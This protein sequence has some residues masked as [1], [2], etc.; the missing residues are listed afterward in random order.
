MRPRIAFRTHYQIDEPAYMEFVVKLC[1]SPVQSAYREVVAHK[2]SQE[3]KKRETKLNEKAAEYAVDLAKDL[4][5]I[6]DNHTWSDTGHLV[7][8]IAQIGNGELEEELSLSLPEKLMHFRVFLEGDGAALLFLARRLIQEKSIKPSEMAWN[9]LAKE[10]FVDVFSKYLAITNNTAD[11]VGIRRQIEAIK[12]SDYQ[13]HSGEHKLFVHLQTLYR[14]GLITTPSP[15]ESRNYC[16]PQSIPGGRGGVAALTEMVPDVPSLEQVLKNHKWIEVAANVFQIEATTW[17]DTS[18]FTSLVAPSYRRVM[19]TGVSL[20]PI[21]T[22]IEAV[23]I[24]L[25]SQES[26]L[27]LWSEAI[28]AMERLQKRRPK[29]VRFHVDRRGQPAFLKMSDE[30]L[31]TYR[32]R[33]VE[34]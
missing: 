17:T 8:L 19:A 25:L 6:T 1:T 32:E 33:E 23:Q 15:S 30:L 5:L 28:E 13:G 9:A 4:G 2:L 34:R 12:T 26:Q 7:N 3:I 31:T 24:E 14:L 16:L 22:L 21:S 10:M 18:G 29:D 11:Q 27:L 20:C